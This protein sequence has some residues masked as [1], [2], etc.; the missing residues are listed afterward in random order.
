MN[1]NEFEWQQTGIDEWVFGIKVRG[2]VRVPLAEIYFDE[3]LNGRGGWMWLV[4][5]K[6]GDVVS[7]E[8]GNAVSLRFAVDETERIMR[9]W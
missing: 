7:T 3:E 2:L 5:R 8:R 1:L 4:H 9:G 6:D